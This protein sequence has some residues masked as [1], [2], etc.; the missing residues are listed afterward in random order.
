VTV[1]PPA[2]TSGSIDIKSTPAGAKVYLDGEDTDFITPIVLTNIS[3]G[4]HTVKLDLYHYKIMEQAGILVTAGETTNLNWALT[5]APQLTY[6]LQ[7]GSEGKDADVGQHYPDMNTG[8]FADL[9][10]GY[11]GGGNYRTYLEFDLSPN[12]LPAGAVV[13]YTDLRLYQFYGSGTISVGAYQVTSSWEENTITW[14]NQPNS[15][16]SPEGITTFGS[17]AGIWRSW[18]LHDLVRGWLDGSISNYGLL[19][20]PTDESSNHSV[21]KFRSSDSSDASNRP[22]L[23][24]YY[25]VP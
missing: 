13:T 14:N 19:L 16:A 6:T 3:A 9:Y 5:Y 12:P 1:N 11:D 18:F 21:A 24:I 8:D 2:V 25:Y 22:C 20:K 15:A 7:P 17:A 4:T 23:K 10:V